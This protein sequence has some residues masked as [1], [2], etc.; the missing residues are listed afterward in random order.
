MNI[1]VTTVSATLLMVETVLLQIGPGKQRLAP[2]FQRENALSLLR[3][4]E[5]V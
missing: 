5:R 4:G 2:G 3:S 1:A